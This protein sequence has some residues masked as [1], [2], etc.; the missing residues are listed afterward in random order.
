MTLE[1]LLIATPA[2]RIHAGLALAAFVLGGAQLW[3]A[4]GTA[5]HRALGWLWCILMVTVAVTSLFIHTICT[6]GG[7]SAIHLL[8][9]VTL[10]AVPLGLWRAH[11]HQVRAHQR[12]MVLLF[13]GAL[14]VAGAFTLMP[15]RILHD[16]VFDTPGRHEACTGPRA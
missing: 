11:R 3:A 4:K 2:V 16:V 14:V 6:V 9:I 12:T 13:V 10:V 7:F 8:S 15:G 1:P 5:R